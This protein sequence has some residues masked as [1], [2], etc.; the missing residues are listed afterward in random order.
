MGGCVGVHEV[1]GW[2]DYIYSWWG[3][4]FNLGEGIIFKL[5]EGLFLIG[6]IFN[7]GEG[8]DARVKR[9]TLRVR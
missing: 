1:T 5:C 7:R 6:I 2:G 4:I 8:L 9:S 3:I